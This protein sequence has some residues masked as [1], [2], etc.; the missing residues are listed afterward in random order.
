MRES[1]DAG[2]HRA[3]RP[4]LRRPRHP[5]QGAARSSRPLANTRS[6]PG[7]SVTRIRPS[8]RKAMHQGCSRPRASGDR[9]APGS[10]RSAP[11]GLSGCD[12]PLACRSQARSSQRG[13]RAAHEHAPTDKGHDRFLTQAGQKTIK[14]VLS[15]Y[16]CATH[17]VGSYYR[18]HGLVNGGMGLV[19]VRN[20]GLSRR[21]TRAS[22]AALSGVDA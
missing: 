21:S 9:P 22:A 4:G 10:P 5:R 15:T 3:V 6:R 1:W 19:R 8:G 11:H 13:S 12:G 17:E 7:R 20:A 18:D 14:L 16:G 2:R